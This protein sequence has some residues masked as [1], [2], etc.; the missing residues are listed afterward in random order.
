MFSAPAVPVTPD[1]TAAVDDA[2]EYAVAD[3][4]PTSNQ[5][6]ESTANTAQDPRQNEIYNYKAVY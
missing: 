2:I 5:G 3:D 4:V 1:L 6:A